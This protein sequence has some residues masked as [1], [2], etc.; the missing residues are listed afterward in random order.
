MERGGPTLIRY[1]RGIAPERIELAPERNNPSLCIVAT[2]DQYPKAKILGEMFSAEVL[3]ARYIK[4]FDFEKMESF[5]KAGIKI[6][7]I[8]NGSVACGIGEMIGSDYRFGWPDR[9]VPHGD[10]ASLE[11]ACAFDVDSIATALEH[12]GFEKVCK[13]SSNG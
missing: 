8:E 1:P 6:A 12:A 5:R 9:F 13:E 2:G 10:I 11:K 4:P 7:S 3:Q